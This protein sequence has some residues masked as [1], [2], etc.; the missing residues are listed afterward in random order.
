MLAD[1]DELL[2]WM[3]CTTDQALADNDWR[4]PSHRAIVDA[5]QFL[6]VTH[7]LPDIGDFEPD[8]ADGVILNLTE[9]IR[10]DILDC[11][12]SFAGDG[13]V[14]IV[15]DHRPQSQCPKI[16]IGPE[17]RSRLRDEIEKVTGKLYILHARHRAVFVD[18]AGPVLD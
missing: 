9:I 10:L 13:H 1:Q 18:G 5:Q 7:P 6:K 15:P 11:V 2:R 16:P 8:A 12:L 17:H 3:R 14:M 4:R